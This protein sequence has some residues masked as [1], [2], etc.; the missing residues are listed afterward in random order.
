LLGILLTYFSCK[1]YRAELPSHDNKIGN[2]SITKKYPILI[3]TRK[4]LSPIMSPKKA[5]YLYGKL[6]FFEDDFA[7]TKPM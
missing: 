4:W 3:C 7:N 6:T 5:K 2:G 1:R